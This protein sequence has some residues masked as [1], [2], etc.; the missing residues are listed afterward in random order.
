MA[1]VTRACTHRDGLLGMT[2]AVAG[3][4][5][6]GPAGTTGS[7]RLPIRITVYRGQ[8]AIHDQVHEHQVA[9]ADT[10]GATQFVFSDSSIAMPTPAAQNVFVFVAFDAP[11]PRR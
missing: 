10:A 7:V 4:V 9:I 3:R 8:E 5:V 11:R 2:V 6:P 1:E